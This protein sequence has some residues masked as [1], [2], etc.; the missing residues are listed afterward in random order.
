VRRHFDDWWSAVRRHTRSER[1]AHFGL[2]GDLLEF[3]RKP[4]G[5]LVHSLC[6]H[7]CTYRGAN[8]GANHGA[9]R[10]S[11]HESHSGT[12]DDGTNS[13]PHR[14]A[15]RSP[16]E[17]DANRRPTVRVADSRANLGTN[18]DTDRCSKHESYSGTHD[19]AADGEPHRCAQRCTHDSNANGC[20]SH[21]GTDRSD[22][23]TYLEPDRCTYSV[24]TDRGADSCAHDEFTDRRT[25][26]IDREPD[27][28][29]AH[30][31]SQCADRR[32][33]GTNGQPDVGPACYSHSDNGATNHT[34]PNSI[35]HHFNA[36]PDGCCCSRIRQFRR[37]LRL[38]DYCGAGWRC[39]GCYCRRSY[40][41]KRNKD[42]EE[43]GSSPPVAT[44]KPRP[45]IV[46]NTAYAWHDYAAPI[47]VAESGLYE[48][49]D[50]PQ[51][52]SLYEMP[53][54]EANR[55]YLEM[56]LRPPPKVAP[57]VTPPSG[58]AVNGRGRG[59]FFPVSG[60]ALPGRGGRGRGTAGAVMYSLPNKQLG[61]ATSAPRVPVFQQSGEYASPDDF[62]NDDDQEETG[63]GFGDFEGQ[64]AD[65][66][67]DP[68]TY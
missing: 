56:T 25:G 5:S 34:L 62:D 52:D 22:T 8:H 55:E 10:R 64:Y 65:P 6:K 35:T 42:A 41:Q 24:C 59:K 40:R 1:G 26:G 27:G 14:C 13:E 15:H 63:F 2:D 45:G 68:S 16:V 67:A 18:R 23:R 43:G 28:G 47:P 50:V 21:R 53:V 48:E 36:Y 33:D 60:A 51:S 57:R 31:H 58:R 44:A 20:P 66:S 7:L 29:S 61:P 19:R 49:T 17:P 37:E 11:K 32:T 3:R 38:H 54:A 4:R 9:D 39:G 46:Q 12:H 30:P